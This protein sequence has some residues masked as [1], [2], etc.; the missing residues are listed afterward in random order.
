[1]LANTR[2]RTASDQAIA[3]I[4]TYG[5]PVEMGRTD[6]L[7]RDVRSGVAFGHLLAGWRR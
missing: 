5:W 7:V 1:M 2:T 4:V 6:V 3:S